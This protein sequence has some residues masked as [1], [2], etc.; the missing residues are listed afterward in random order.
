M[1]E[2]KTFAPEDVIVPGETTRI[3]ILPMTRDRYMGRDGRLRVHYSFVT[4]GGFKYLVASTR[5]GIC[6]VI[7]ASA[8]WQPEDT[9]R[10]HFPHA[11]VRPMSVK[12]HRK[13]AELL[14]RHYGKVRRLTLHLYGT[15]FQ[16]AVWREL[17]RIP[18]GKVTTYRTIAR[19]VGRPR[20]ARAVGRAV[21]CNPVMTIIPCHRVVCADGSIGG[22]RWTI[23]RK[24]RMLNSEARPAAKIDNYRNWNPRLL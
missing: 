8:Q 23:K 15:P 4:A 1:A 24:V 3:T 9:L 12:L 7:P 11:L 19:L 13:A 6:M 18:S 14:K 2:D 10:R 16:I 20:A 5:E 21:S 22:Y 17:L